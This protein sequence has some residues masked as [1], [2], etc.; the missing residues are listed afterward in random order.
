MSREVLAVKIQI[1]M[2]I[3][4]ETCSDEADRLSQPNQPSPK[5]HCLGSF[6]TEKNGDF[7]SKKLS[8]RKFRATYVFDLHTYLSVNIGQ[9]VGSHKIQL[10]IHNSPI[11]RGRCYDHNFLR[12]FAN[13]LRKIWRFSLKTNAMMES[14][15]KYSL[16]KKCQFFRKHFYNHY[17]G[18]LSAY[19]IGKLLTCN[20]IV[21]K[22]DI[23]T[24]KLKGRL[25]EHRS[26]CM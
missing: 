7:G 22:F 9:Y 18:P 24:R 17:I 16:N 10:K 14:L 11:T 21:T 1:L 2:P 26:S 8:S 13:F 19:Y 23:C 5:T 6:S 15:H 12:F 3:Q 20:Y 4:G 25:H